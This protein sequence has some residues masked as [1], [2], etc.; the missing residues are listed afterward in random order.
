MNARVHSRTVPVPVLISLLVA[1]PLAAEQGP[2]PVSP[3]GPRIG[4]VLGG[5]GAKGAAHIGVLRVLDEMRI[6]ISCVVG[7]SMG[8]LVGG[9][10][11]SGMPPEEIE[12]EVLAINWSKTVGSEGARDRMPINRK[13]AGI[14]YTNS[15]DLGIKGGRLQGGGGLLKSQNIEDVIRGLVTAARSTKDFDDLPIPF[16]AVATDMLAGDMVVLEDGDLS[17]AMRASMSVPGAFSPVL[18]EGMVLADGGMMRNLPVDVARRLCADVVIAVSLESPAPQ[19]ENLTTTLDLASRSLDVMIE[20]N[21]KAQVATL[22]DVDVSIVVPMGDIGSAS[23]QRIPEAVPL[24]RAAALAQQAKLRRYA[25]PEDQYLAW[26]QSLSRESGSPMRLA[27]V[28]VTGLKRVSPDYVRTQLEIVAPGKQVTTAQIVADTARIYALGD[29]ERVEYVLSG[30]RDATTLEVRAVEKSWGPRFVRFDLGFTASG[31]GNLE[32]VIRADYDR[33]WLNQRGG[34]WRNAIQF[35][36]QS[37]LQTSLYQPLDVPQH[38][39][40]EPLI[41]FENDRE[42]IYDEGDRVATYALRQLYGQIDAG[43]NLGPRAQI[44]AGLRSGWLDAQRDTG[45][46]VL[47]NIDRQVDSSAQLRFV[48][49]TRNDASLPTRGT[50]LNARLVSSGAWLGGQESYGLAEGVL[51]KFYPFRGDALSFILGGG[52]RLNGQLPPTQEFQL[53]GIRTFPGLQYGELRGDSYW[54]AGT[55]Y[56]WKIADI[57]S[58]FGQTIYAGLRLQAGR[59]GEP[60]D[61]ADDGAVYGISGNLGANT[62]LGPIILSLGYVDNDSWA[63][64]LAIGRP[65][66]EGS[67]L[68]EAR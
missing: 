63:L 22:T 55:R 15:L 48:Y 51:S 42:D 24:G 21:Q 29:F 30:P 49:D 10:F 37:L 62:P 53:G 26:R 11:A 8:A 44:R 39:F 66:A 1:L 2:P 27:D 3:A 32:A 43:M 28:K 20:A 6:P 46:T 12:R 16:R 59:M 23:F 50:F 4:L 61:E 35:G 60:I 41:R 25:L 56:N 68:D 14:T 19:P 40:I 57:Q 52:K 36:Q 31:V 17:V 33:T 18:M 47:P 45:A 54:V 67:I 13:L 34:E 65:I 5:G 38:F 9:T 7:T 58:L 64:Q